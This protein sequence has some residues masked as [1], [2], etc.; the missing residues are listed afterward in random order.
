ME[1]REHTGFFG[2]PVQRPELRA[3]PRATADGLV[4]SSLE[5]ECSVCGGLW[6]AGCA[7]A[8]IEAGSNALTL[9]HLPSEALVARARPL[10]DGR[11]LVNGQACTAAGAEVAITDWAQL[12]RGRDPLP[13]PVLRLGGAHLAGKSWA[14]MRLAWGLCEAGV[15]VR[16]VPVRRVVDDL[17]ALADRRQPDADDP[18]A[19]L[20]ARPPRV[21]VLDCAEAS[22][23]HRRIYEVL[24][25]DR[26]ERGLP[27]MI[28]SA[29]TRAELDDAVGPRLAKWLGARSE[30]VVFAG[31]SA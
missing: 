18:L 27:T 6:K 25:Q 21:V 4:A 29:L 19:R 20:M 28:T 16:W 5:G 2:R 13:R 30:V 9:A 10:R 7:C 3:V 22:G 12:A 8:G 14:A 11:Y 24:L 23:W 17:Q 26:V 1:G 15:R 31:E